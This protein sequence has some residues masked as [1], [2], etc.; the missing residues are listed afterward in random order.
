[1]STLRLGVW[2]VP[3]SLNALRFICDTQVP[4]LLLRWDV[5]HQEASV[6]VPGNNLILLEW[7]LPAA[8]STDSEKEVNDFDRVVLYLHGGAYSLCRP[9][10]LRWVTDNVAASLGTAVCVPEY[11]RPPEHPIPAPMED[12]LAVY[13]HLLQTMPHVE[14]VLAGESAG[15]GIVAAT[16][17]ALRT[18]ALPMP[19]CA[20]LVSPWTDLGN[21]GLSHASLENEGVDYLT[22]SK[23]TFASEIARGDLLDDDWRA[24]P[25]HVNGDLSSLPPMLVIYGANEILRAQIEYFCEVWVGKGANIRT[26]AVENGAH[27]PILFRS[28]SAAADEALQDMAAFVHARGVLRS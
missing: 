20:V 12:A 25:V 23:V 15:G 14:I 9:G 16:L 21:D 1:M 11:R 7:V 24:S 5:R 13:R 19:A 8:T 27:A 17:A 28:V 3:N 4:R 26:R 18:E 2:C 6:E 22:A 10:T